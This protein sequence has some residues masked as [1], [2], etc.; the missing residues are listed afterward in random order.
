MIYFNRPYRF[1]FIKSCIP[2][3]LL[4]PFWNILSHWISREAIKGCVTYR[5]SYA[6]GHN[7][8]CGGGG[9]GWGVITNDVLKFRQ[10]I[11]LL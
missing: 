8:A 5:F 9:G 4:C 3:I 7:D 2:L 10:V 1:Q 6:I 11:E